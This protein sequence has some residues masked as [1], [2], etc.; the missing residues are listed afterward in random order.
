MLASRSDFDLDQLGPL[1][2]RGSMAA[3]PAQPDHPV[4]TQLTDLHSGATQRPRAGVAF[5][6]TSLLLS[7][8]PL[9]S[10]IEQ[11]LATD[12]LP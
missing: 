4:V 3:D 12:L 5:A 7:A 11:A 8:L 1:R 2:F 10:G 9:P 6:S